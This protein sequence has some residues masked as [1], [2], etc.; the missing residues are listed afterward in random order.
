MW[1]TQAITKENYRPGSH[2]PQR[3]NLRGGHEGDVDLRERKQTKAF[4]DFWWAWQQGPALDSIGA[5]VPCLRPSNCLS[6]PLGLLCSLLSFI[7]KTTV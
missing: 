5:A 6:S 3:V 2:E 1:L 4:V 7:F